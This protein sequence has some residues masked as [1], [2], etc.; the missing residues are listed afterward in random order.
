MAVP[1]LH[2]VGRKQGNLGRWSRTETGNTKWFSQS[3]QARC[4]QSSLKVSG[5]WVGQ[6]RGWGN[7][8]FARTRTNKKTYTKQTQQTPA[9][10]DDLT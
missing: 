9:R 1:R 2:G 10:S 6:S 4:K 5:I 8:I 3:D 7:H